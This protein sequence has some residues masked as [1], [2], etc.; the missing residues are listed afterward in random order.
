MKVK[1]KPQIV[2]DKF[3]I[4]KYID[5]DLLARETDEKL[6]RVKQ[7]TD[8]FAKQLETKEKRLKEI[9]IR[10]RNL[11]FKYFEEYDEERFDEEIEIEKE[12]KLLHQE[13][14]KTCKSEK[15]L[16]NETCKLIEIYNLKDELKYRAENIIKKLKRKINN[17]IED[18]HLI[19]EIVKEEN[20]NCKYF[21]QIHFN[22][23]GVDV[24]Y[25]V[26]PVIDFEIT[27]KIVITD[28]KV[29]PVVLKREEIR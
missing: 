1:L 5:N 21:P 11:P 23:N 22:V 20:M 29:F 27:D 24:Y 4:I 2:I 18:K 7:K 8:E 13:I 15:K 17:L 19:A 25:F 3:N 26:A 14:T 6:K 16:H 12:V 10:A 9:S 28:F